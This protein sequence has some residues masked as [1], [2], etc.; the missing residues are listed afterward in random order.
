MVN[1]DL[2]VNVVDL[3]AVAIICA[4]TWSKIHGIRPWNTMTVG[5]VDQTLCKQKETGLL[6]MRRT[7]RETR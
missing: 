5:D 2:A 1:N 4:E 6:Y 3:D 7:V